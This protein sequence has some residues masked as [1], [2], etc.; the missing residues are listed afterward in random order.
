MTVIKVDFVNKLIKGED[1]LD[2]LD[3][4]TSE[5]LNEMDPSSLMD[6]SELEMYNVW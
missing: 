6:V 4:E 1:A 2:H 3:V 5:F